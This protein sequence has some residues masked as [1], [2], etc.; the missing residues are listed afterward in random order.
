[1]ITVNISNLPSNILKLRIHLVKSV[2]SDQ[3][4]K[5]P[6][7]PIPGPI[8][9]IVDAETAKDEIKS[10]LEVKDMIIDRKIKIII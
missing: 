1:M 4:P 10:V 8:F 9:P 7:I 3:L 2:N 5:G 6:I